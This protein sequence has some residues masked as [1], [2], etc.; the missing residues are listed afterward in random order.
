MTDQG[1]RSLLPGAAMRAPYGMTPG[2]RAVLPGVNDG[3]ATAWNRH[4]EPDQ[5]DL[6]APIPNPPQ[7]GPQ[8]APGQAPPG[9]APAA[10][11]P[12][13]L[14]LTDPHGNVVHLRSDDGRQRD[15]AQVKAL[16]QALLGHAVS[17]QEKTVAQRAIDWGMSQVGQ[18][19]IDS[20]RKEMTHY[21]DV[22]SGGILKTD[23]QAMKSKANRGGVGGVPA[24]AV[25]ANG[26]PDPMTKMGFKLDDAMR[27]R[28]E[29]IIESERK[30]TKSAALS[31]LD[32]SLREMEANLNSNN[33]MA[34]RMAQMQQLLA[35][36]GKAST[37]AER[38]GITASSGKWEEL[39]NKLS[40][41]TS[42]DPNLSRAYVAKFQRYIA[43]ERENIRKAREQIAVQTATG[44]QSAVSGFGPDAQKAIGDYVYGRMSGRFRGGSYV[45]P[46]DAE[47]SG[48]KPAAP[49]VASPPAAAP[50]AAPADNS[51]LYAP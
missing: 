37:A 21:W 34:E 32:N 25:G 16:G 14:E 17:E 42:S 29:Q 49:P 47:V 39:K 38:E 12:W 41:W 4:P 6:D 46:T 44:A 1:P 23:L 19:D 28:A 26:L 10:P 15:E 36:T 50:Q 24:P 27:D 33:P 18:N 30:N 5:I 9:A 35:M 13:G 20:I 7:P 3:S 22:G 11:E 8:A 31:A 40:L 51:D 45:P 2:V 43:T 48:G